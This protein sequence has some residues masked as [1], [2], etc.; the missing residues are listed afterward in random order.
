MFLVDLIPDVKIKRTPKMRTDEKKIID[1]IDASTSQ[2]NNLHQFITSYKDQFGQSCPSELK[3]VLENSV[4]L[5]NTKISEMVTP[6][7]LMNSNTNTEFSLAFSYDKWDNKFK[8]EKEFKNIKILKQPKVDIKQ[9][10]NV[11]NKVGLVCIPEVFANYDVI[12]S[13]PRIP[14]KGSYYGIYP[15]DL[16]INF[17]K[18]CNKYGLTVWMVAPIKYY[19]V[20]EHA[21]HTKYEMYSPDYIRQSLMAVKIILPMLINMTDKMEKLSSDVAEV[22]AQINIIKGQIQEQQNQIRSLQ[23]ELEVFQARQA[24]EKQARDEEFNALVQARQQIMWAD[25]DPLLIAVPSNVTNINT[26]E[27]DVFLGPCWGP[28]VDEVIIKLHDMDSNVR[29]NYFQENLTRWK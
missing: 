17:E 19:S 27:G 3:A 25:A 22:K 2:L 13:D 8:A 14:H 18:E 11:A 21:K 15:K 12:D 16:I 9:V 29:K 7:I 10:L 24:A 6:D 23:V 5:L 20:A 28:E 4:A 1:M 26:Y